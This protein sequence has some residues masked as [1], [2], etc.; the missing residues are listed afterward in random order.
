M[1][2]EYDKIRAKLTKVVE[3]AMEGGDTPEVVADVV[4]KAAQA[5]KPQLRYTAG[6]AAS[7]LKFLRRFAPASVLDKGIRKSLRIDEKG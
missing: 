3:E 7:Q 1:L 5:T 2:A 6:K 4:V